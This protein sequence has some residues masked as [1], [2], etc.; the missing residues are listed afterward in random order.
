MINIKSFYCMLRVPL[1][2]II[3]ELFKSSFGSPNSSDEINEFTQYYIVFFKIIVPCLIFCSSLCLLIL[4]NKYLFVVYLHVAS[5]CIVLFSYW[6]NIQTLLFLSTYYKT[7]KADMINEIITLSD[8]IIYFFTK[9]EL[10]QLL[11][12]YLIQYCLSLVFEFAHVFTINHSVPDIFRYCFFI[13]ILFASIFKTG[14]IL[15]MITI[16]STLVQL[17][18]MLKTLWL[19]VPI[20]KNLIRDGYDFAQEIITNFGVI[21]L[22]RR[23]WYRLRMLRIST[24][25]R[26]FWVTR[27]LIQILHNQ[28]YIELQNETL[29]GA[30]KYLLIK[31]SD[32]FTAVLGMAC[33]LSFFCECIEVVFL[34]V[35][36]VDEFDGI[37]SGINCAITFVIMAWTSG[38]TG[39]N[40]EIRLKQIY[41]SIYLIHVVWQHYIH[42]MVHK[43][44]ISLNDS[45]NSSFN[46]HLRPLLVCGYL[47]VSAVTIL[48]YL[49]SYYLYSDWLLAISCLYII[50]VIKVL[51]T[52]TVYSL[53]LIDIYSSIPL[54]NLDEYV[55]HINFLGD[56]VEFHLSIY[57]LPQ[58]ILI[59]VLTPG[60]IVHAFITCLQVY[61]KICFL[62]NKMENFAKRCTAL[63]KIRSLPQATS[64]QLS[65]FNDICAICYQNMRS[66]RITA[67]NHYFHSECLRK[68]FYIKDLCPMC[69][70]SV[71]F[72]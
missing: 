44:L 34:R 61:S 65:E 6:T 2:F 33:F 57:F 66:A 68:W 17:F 10:Y 63:K 52:L 19:N 70:T 24:V 5:V 36:M 18:T 35:L 8:F 30:V 39:L 7:I 38:L 71:F 20:I 22:I 32:T 54:E 60:D 72:E 43:L 53:L 58:N 42:K 4:P 15:N 16:F 21:N 47:L 64:S 31:G 11:S 29:F 1:I 55:Y 37:Y 67:C 56:M 49:W 26:I 62:K 28:A 25:L 48:I 13:P 46:R 59:M 12:N 9:S 45:R 41:G 51:V 3:D 23:E 40:P 27:V 50:T 69:Q 14:T